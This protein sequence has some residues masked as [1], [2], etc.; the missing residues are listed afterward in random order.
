MK[1]C[2]LFSSSHLFFRESGVRV[3]YNG[4]ADGERTAKRFLP[5]DSSLTTAY[6]DHNKF[7]EAILHL[8]A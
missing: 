4:H 2:G 1:K 7:L 6:T 5:A 8:S 3:R